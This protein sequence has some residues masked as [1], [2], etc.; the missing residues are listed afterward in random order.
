MAGTSVL[1]Y[2]RKPVIL[3]LGILLIVCIAAFGGNFSGPA[4]SRSQQKSGQL[5]FVKRPLGINR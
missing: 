3:G 4:K 2:Q 5:E 1:V